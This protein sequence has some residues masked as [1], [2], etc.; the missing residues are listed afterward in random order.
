MIRRHQ[1]T[2]IAIISGIIFL[3]AMT[4]LLKNNHVLN[5][6]LLSSSKPAN[7]QLSLENNRPIIQQPIK[8]SV[9][10]DSGENKV[11]VIGIY[12]HFDPQKLQVINMDTRASFCQFYP[13]K[14]FDNHLGTITLS[15]GSPHPGFSGENTAIVL[16]F[17]PIQ[18]GKTQILTDPKSSLLASNGKGTNLLAQFPTLDLTIFTGL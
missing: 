6:P 5:V 3:L 13:E 11:N 12:L 16:D 10:V 9:R 8:V 1:G 7:L 4:L 15:C 18:I 17:L 2:L 14:K